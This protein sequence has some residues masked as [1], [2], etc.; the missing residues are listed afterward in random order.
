MRVSA[1]EPVR[2]GSIAIPQHV[3]RSGVGHKAANP[4]AVA[5]G[6]VPRAAVTLAIGR[7]LGTAIDRLAS[8][9]QQKKSR[10]GVQRK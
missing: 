9:E 2:G 7:D 1:E 10:E 4:G 5:A 8:E 3:A 6:N